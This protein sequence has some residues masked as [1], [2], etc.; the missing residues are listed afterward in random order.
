MRSGDCYDVKSGLPQPTAIAFDK[1]GALWST[2]K[3]LVPNGAEV[4]KVKEARRKWWKHP[5]HLE[6]KD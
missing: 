3:A 6:F 4:V 2:Q 5:H 1:T